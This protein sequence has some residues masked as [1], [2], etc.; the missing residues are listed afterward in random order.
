MFRAFVFICILLNSILGLSQERVFNTGIIGGLTTAQI[1]GDAIGGFN[2]IGFN[3]GGFVNVDLRN[4]FSAEF[5]MYFINKGSRKNPS[6]W[7]RS[8]WSIRLN[9]IEVPILLRYKYKKITAELG[10]AFGRMINQKFLAN[11]RKYTADSQRYFNKNEFSGIAGFQYQMKSNL[12]LNLRYSQSLWKVRSFTFTY[13]RY[14]IFA[15]QAGSVN[16]LISISLKYQFGK[17]T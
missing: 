13:P 15:W 5:D 12:S 4:S 10:L 1:H 16:T 6:K 3:F 14:Y 11:G 2:K 8:Y 7:D 17:K 9:Y